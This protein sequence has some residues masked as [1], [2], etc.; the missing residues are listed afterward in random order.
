MTDPIFP[1][2]RQFVRLNKVKDF[3]KGNGGFYQA[4]EII[5]N[6]LKLVCLLA[7]TALPFSIH[8][9]DVLFRPT[10][11]TSSLLAR[12]VT[13]MD[14]SSLLRSSYADDRPRS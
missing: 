6:F 14:G 13:G 5:A 11:E 4:G 9:L 7:D 1:R 3:I 8:L 12:S 2:G 10:L